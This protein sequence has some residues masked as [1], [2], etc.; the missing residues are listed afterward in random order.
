MLW[1]AII[2]YD[3]V[4]S[5]LISFHL[6]SNLILS[7]S[8]S[9][10]LPLSISVSVLYIHMHACVCLCVCVYLCL[11]ASFVVMYGHIDSAVVALTATRCEYDG[12]LWVGCVHQSAYCCARGAL[13]CMIV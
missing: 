3:L 5:H 9:P 2:C 11:C 1:Y 7:D 6:S 8:S 10:Y 4:S 13:S 12:A